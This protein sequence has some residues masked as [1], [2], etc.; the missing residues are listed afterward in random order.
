MKF[1]YFLQVSYDEFHSAGF[2][3]VLTKSLG[4]F[5]R[6]LNQLKPGLLVEIIELNESP[7]E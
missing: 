6:G 2:L 3:L 5:H 7:I 4:C 1:V